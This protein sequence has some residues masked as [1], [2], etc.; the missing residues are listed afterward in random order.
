M[1]SDLAPAVPDDVMRA[2]AVRRLKKKRD[3][4]AHVLVYVLMNAF[5][6]VIWAMSGAGSFFWPIFLIVPWGIGL[7]MNG[8]DVY[9]GEDFTEAQIR[10]EMHRLG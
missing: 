10:R 2:R 8:W 3:F 7:V 6:V 9:R 1:A 5:V 4:Y